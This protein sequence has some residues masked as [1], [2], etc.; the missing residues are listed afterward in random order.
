MKGSDALRRVG[1]QT[2]LFRYAMGPSVLQ[3][4]RKTKSFERELYGSARVARVLARP[5]VCQPALVARGLGKSE[6]IIALH[7]DVLAAHGKDSGR[8]KCG[9]KAQTLGAG[10]VE[11]VDGE[12]VEV[13]KKARPRVDSALDAVVVDFGSFARLKNWVFRAIDGAGLVV[14][15]VDV[16]VARNVL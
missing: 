2:E 5:R 7:L 3:V 15:T 4:A 9:F 14:G 8:L 11:R 13:H 10:I 6:R 12:G 1:V 16:E